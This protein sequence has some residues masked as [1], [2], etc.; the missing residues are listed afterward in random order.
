VTVPV[1]LIAAVA[2]NGVIG[3]DGRIPW[4]LP[5]DFAF[6]KRTTMG[7]PLVMGRRTFESIGR[8]LPGRTSIVVTRRRD[9][10]PEGVIA[11]PDLGEALRRAQEIAAAGGAAEVMVGGGALVYAEAMP[12][13]QRLYVTHVALAPEGD[14]RFP[15][16]DPDEWRVAER[17]DVVATARDSAGFVVNVYARREP[18]RR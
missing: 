8:P 13:A 12:L 14:T 16:I 9:Y 5:T 10:A 11:A 7:K 4:R 3:A 6:F 15:P 2:E 18:R 1:A 17:P